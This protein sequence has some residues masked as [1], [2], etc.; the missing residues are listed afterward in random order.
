MKIQRISIKKAQKKALPILLSGFEKRHQMRSPEEDSR[1]ASE[2]VARDRQT[3]RKPH[4]S[5]I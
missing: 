5:T 2:K 4:L 1:R 3:A